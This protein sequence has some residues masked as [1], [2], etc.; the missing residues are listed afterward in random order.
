MLLMQEDY[1]RKVKGKL[2]ADGQ[3]LSTM[4]YP[5]LVWIRFNMKLTK[6]DRSRLSR[7]LLRR[8]SLNLDFDKDGKKVMITE[9]LPTWEEEINNVMR[10]M[11]VRS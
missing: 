8:E 11:Q 6:L 4:P 7:E 9:K 5:K 1:I 3:P 2:V 10:E